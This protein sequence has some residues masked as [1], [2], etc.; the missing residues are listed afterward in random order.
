MRI[1][2]Q[3]ALV[4]LRSSQHGR[5]DISPRRERH[6]FEY[7][8]HCGGAR[9]WRVVWL[10]ILSRFRGILEYFGLGLGTLEFETLFSSMSPL[11]GPLTDIVGRVL[12]SFSHQ[13]SITGCDMTVNTQAAQHFA[14]TLHE[15][16]TNAAKYGASSVPTG[17]VSITCTCDGE[18][19]PSHF[20]GRS[21]VVQ[22]FWRRSGRGLAA[23]S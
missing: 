21:P 9:P 6:F 7:A 14:L 4:K 1:Y 8:C 22:W 20:C 3:P 13:L 23:L 15:L 18:R 2:S 10:S 12:A 5:A 17:S 11:G 16:A 19:K